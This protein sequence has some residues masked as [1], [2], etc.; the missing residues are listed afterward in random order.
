MR[1]TAPSSPGRAGTGSGVKGRGSKVGGQGSRVKGRPRKAFPGSR[2][3]WDRSP[4]PAPRP[5]GLRG[6]PG[7]ASSSRAA[8]SGGEGRGGR[9]GARPLAPPGPAQPRAATPRHATP[10]HSPTWRRRDRRSRRSRAGNALRDRLSPAPKMADVSSRPGVPPRPPPGRPSANRDAAPAPAAPLLALF[11]RPPPVIGPSPKPLLAIGSRR[12]SIKRE[13]GGR[14]F[15]PINSGV[16][17]EF[18]TPKLALQRRLGEPEPPG[19]VSPPQHLPCAVATARAPLDGRVAPPI[20]KQ[21][22]FETK[23]SSTHRGPRSRR[24]ANR[25]ARRTRGGGRGRI[26]V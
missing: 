19:W 10:R 2:A 25:E 4:A 3:R 5:A 7:A 16:P 17:A 23:A 15:F 6:A 26:E 13:G 1:P 14:A 9:W 22:L 20:R 8:D 12:L 11:P 21:K 18:R 24:G